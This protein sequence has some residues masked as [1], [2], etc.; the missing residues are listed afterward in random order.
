MCIFSA[1][2]EAQ[3]LKKLGE[4][5]SKQ[6][7]QKMEKRTEQEVDKKT[8][9]AL[10][11]LLAPKNKSENA[12]RNYSED[13]R[14]KAN[15]MMEAMMGGADVKT[16]NSYTFPVIAT[17]EIEDY[18]RKKSDITKMKQG[19]GDSALYM[20]MEE[21]PDNVIITDMKNEAMIMVDNK[22]GTASVMSL[23][24][25]KKMGT[26]KGSDYE[27]NGNSN[28]VDIRKTGNRK[29]ISG[30]E[31]EEYIFTSE[32]GKMHAWFAPDVP[33]DYKDYIEGFTSMFNEK[34]KS[35]PMMQLR[36]TYG[37]MMEMV[38]Y[39][40]KGEKDSRMTVTDISEDGQTVNMGNLKVQGMMDAAGN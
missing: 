17:I 40:K 10:D 28:D 27:G 31:C 29:T 22:K 32:D 26:Y 9:A 8:D 21:S 3:F 7:E 12:N 4:K 20:V 23:A 1:K 34:Q 30:Y 6:M 5:V 33:F 38:S 16:E 15:A 35:N 37:Y 14:D 13:D 11:S 18:G 24:W 36:E 2:S 39:D 25:M 19:F